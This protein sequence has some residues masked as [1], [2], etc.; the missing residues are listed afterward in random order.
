MKLRQIQRMELEIVQLFFYQAAE[1]IVHQ[2]GC[3]LVT[4]SLLSTLR[5]YGPNQDTARG[6]PQATGEG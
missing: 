6:C 4:W 3:L 2:A 5:G 1:M